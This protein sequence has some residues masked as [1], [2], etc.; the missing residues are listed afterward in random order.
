VPSSKIICTTDRPKMVRERITSTFGTF[1]MAIS[2][3][4]VTCRSTSS[5]ARPG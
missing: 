5:G 2:T 4:I 1:R 3:G